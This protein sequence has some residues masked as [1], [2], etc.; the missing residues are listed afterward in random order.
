VD[1]LIKT[2]NH[3]AMKRKSNAHKEPVVEA[4]QEPA[5]D[6]RPKRVRKQV[7]RI[8]SSELRS[9]EMRSAIKMSPTNPAREEKHET[10]R[11]GRGRIIARPSQDKRV[12]RRLDKDHEVLDLIH[13]DFL[14]F[15][16]LL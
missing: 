11:P 12:K 10:N 1:D 5:E 16:N 9:S 15:R 8:R 14:T 4:A 6:G 3:F 7:E 2:A 13:C